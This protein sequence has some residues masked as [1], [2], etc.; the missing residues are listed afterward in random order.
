RSPFK[1]AA[2]ALAISEVMANPK[3][4]P[5]EE[6]FEIANVGDGAFDLNDLAL[7]RAGDSRAPEVISSA[8][9]KPVPP[10]DF[11]LFAR[12]ADPASNGMLPPVDATFGFSLVNSHGD[13]RVLDGT[14]VLDAA[15]WD[16]SSDGVSMQR[17][18]TAC[19]AVTP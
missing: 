4:E 10:G 5:A 15:M 13:V 3:I 9:C 18:P 12:S 2:A 11:A 1:P 17:V 16:A 6:W 7:D 8:A 14:T 19:P